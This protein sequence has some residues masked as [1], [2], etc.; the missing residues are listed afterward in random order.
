MFLLL[1]L[2]TSVICCLIAFRFR[3]TSGYA[4]VNVNA[5]VSSSNSSEAVDF[6]R[7]VGILFPGHFSA[8]NF[9]IFLVYK[10]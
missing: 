7:K 8:V 6:F 10:K 9:L 2:H 4:H 5:S 3:P 1:S